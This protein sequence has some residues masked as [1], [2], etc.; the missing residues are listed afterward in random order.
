[1]IIDLMVDEKVGAVPVV[2]GD[3]NDLVG[4]VSYVDVLRA[5]RETLD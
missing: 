1:E 2:E 3:S 4:L 5:L